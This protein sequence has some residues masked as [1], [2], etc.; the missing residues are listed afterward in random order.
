[1]NKVIYDNN[2][3]FDTSNTLAAR[4]FRAEIIMSK[5]WSL[6]GVLRIKILGPVTGVKGTQHCN[7]G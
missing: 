7:F 5:T 3:P 1:M 2:E 4:S 6:K